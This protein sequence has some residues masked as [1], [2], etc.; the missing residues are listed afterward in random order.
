M[1]IHQLTGAPY[2]TLL[3]ERI[4]T[5]L[6]MHATRHNAVR[7]IVPHRASGYEWCDGRL[8]NADRLPGRISILAVTYAANGA[9][10]SLLSTMP[11]LITWDAALRSERILQRSSAEQLW[12]PIGLNN[13]IPVPYAHDWTVKE[14]RGHN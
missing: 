5:P 6:G 14:H 2:D 13:G 11:D 10:G 4:F 7:A 9:N 8:R 1:I 3:D 12:S